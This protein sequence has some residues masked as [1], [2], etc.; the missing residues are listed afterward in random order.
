MAP[1]IPN[2]TH[3]VFSYKRSSTPTVMLIVLFGSFSFV[4][5]ILFFVVSV[6]H[7]EKGS[8]GGYG[9]NNPMEKP[10]E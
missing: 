5:I 3:S 7:F 1:D 6:L 2:K 8:D 4:I 9:T 10:H